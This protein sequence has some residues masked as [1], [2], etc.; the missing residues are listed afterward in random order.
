MRLP[1]SSQLF[2]ERLAA[3]VKTSAR[4]ALSTCVYAGFV[5]I[6]QIAGACQFGQKHSHRTQSRN[7]LRGFPHH[8][9]KLFFARLCVAAVNTT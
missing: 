2:P 5:T 3:M 1:V 4:R 6:L 8:G 9:S 7:A